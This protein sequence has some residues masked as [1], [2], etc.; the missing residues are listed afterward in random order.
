MEIL[1][2]D[3][4]TPMTVEEY[5]AKYGSIKREHDNS[6]ASELVDRG[7]KFGKDRHWCEC[8]FQKGDKVLI[9]GP[10]ITGDNIWKDKKCIVYGVGMAPFD[11]YTIAHPSVIDESGLKD[12][13]FS[14]TLTFPG[15]SLK[16][17][18]KA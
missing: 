12:L 18:R 14:E 6:Y 7:E 17:L 16:M 13:D 1:P 10:S 15:E 4:N 2:E 8:K 11:Y 9:V 5:E 3:L